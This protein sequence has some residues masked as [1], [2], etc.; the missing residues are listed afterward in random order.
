MPKHKNVCSFLHQTS[1]TPLRIQKL[2]FNLLQFSSQ[3]LYQIRVS[4]YLHRLAQFLFK[5]KTTE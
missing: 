3:I 2:G 4:L 5:G 1:M